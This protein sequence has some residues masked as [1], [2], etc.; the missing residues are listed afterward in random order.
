[1]GLHA[2]QT[3]RLCG[4]PARRIGEQFVSG[5]CRGFR[6]GDRHHRAGDANLP[7]FFTA[8]LDEFATGTDI[9]GQTRH[10]GGKPFEDH[11]RHA[12][13]DRGQ[14]HQAHFRQDLGDVLEAEKLDVVFQTE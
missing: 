13:G 8:A 2:F 10:T 1:M 11:Q 5:G 12:F 6:I 14:H 9:R 3:G 7:I 4:T